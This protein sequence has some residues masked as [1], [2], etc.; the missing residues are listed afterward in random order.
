MTAIKAQ[1]RINRKRR[2]RSRIHGTAVR[3][4]LVVYRSN[5]NLSVQLIDDDKGVTLVSASNMKAKE[6]NVEAAKVVGTEVAKKALEKK[7]T[8][9]V[10]D[11]NGYN[12]H[13]KV[14]ALADA[15]RENGLQ[16]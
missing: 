1:K 16:F 13:G 7:I 9:C 3:P 8:T 6:N 4:R 11:R 5:R 2:I 12:Y 10:F 14:K 15:A